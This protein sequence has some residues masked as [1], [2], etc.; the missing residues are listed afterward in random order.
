MRK[1]LQISGAGTT[2]AVDRLILVANDADILA[3]A[4]KQT[5]QLFLRGVGVLK[6]VDHQVA[7][8]RTPGGA[9]IGVIAQQVDGAEKQIVEIERGRFAQNFVI[10]AKNFGD[11]AALVIARLA[12]LRLHFVGGGAVI[13]RMAY[14]GAQTARRVVVCGET[15][16]GESALDG[17]SLIV[18]VVDGE[19]ARQSEMAGFAAQKASAEGMKRG[20]PNVGGVAST[21]AK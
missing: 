21:G 17:G 7:E 11:I 1:T 14:L 18:V 3:L 9:D 19:I 12:G 15:E 13:F 8:T 16:R 20:N 6:F 5:H 4:G 2:P 10:C